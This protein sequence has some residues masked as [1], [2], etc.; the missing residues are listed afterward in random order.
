MNR[1]LWNTIS[2]LTSLLHWPSLVWRT[3]LR[4][5][6]TSIMNFTMCRSGTALD[7]VRGARQC[8]MQLSDQVTPHQ[9]SLFPESCLLFLCQQ[10]YLV[11]RWSALME[12]SPFPQE[13]WVHRSCGFIT[14][15]TMRVMALLCIKTWGLTFVW[16][17]SQVASSC[18][19]FFFGFD[20]F[21]PEV[22]GTVLEEKMNLRWNRE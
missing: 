10:S 8:H 14:V 17:T 5:D 11:S 9:L 18:Q 12:T 4:F 19:A 1:L 3:K 20:L 7:G 22:N 21:F 13:L 15:Y 2:H 16:D 6:S